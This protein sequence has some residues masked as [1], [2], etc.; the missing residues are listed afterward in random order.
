M[1]GT[2]KVGYMGPDQGPFSCSNCKHYQDKK[3]GSGC[4]QSEVIAELGKGE[5]GL[6]PV[7][8][9]GCCN[10]FEKRKG[11]GDMFVF[12]ANQRKKKA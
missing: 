6:A 5:N 2:P 12:A 1:P 11:M 8:P 10:E 3:D 7:S 4:N 9:Q